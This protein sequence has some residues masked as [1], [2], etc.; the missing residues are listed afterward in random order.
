MA[1]MLELKRS[2][3]GRWLPASGG[4]SGSRE[5][6]TFLDQTEFGLH[7][8]STGALLDSPMV[9]GND[10]KFMKMEH[11]GE[12]ARDGIEPPTPAFSGLRST[13]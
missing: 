7:L 1:T 5:S 9:L 4:G 3:T 12:V 2:L 10:Y 6:H 13:N 11:L 8:D